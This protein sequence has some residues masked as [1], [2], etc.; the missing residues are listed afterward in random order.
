MVNPHRNEASF[1]I[2]GEIY[3]LRATFGALAEIEAASLKAGLGER[4]GVRYALIALQ[5]M[6]KAG[7][8]EIPQK[9]LID[10]EASRLDDVTAAI[11]E[12]MSGPV[13]EKN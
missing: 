6:S 5:E 4:Y 2:A 7:G 8:R 10:M 11:N 3:T 9:A 1:E 13:Q 12:A